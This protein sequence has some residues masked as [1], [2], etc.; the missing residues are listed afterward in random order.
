MP[1][2]LPSAFTAGIAVARTTPAVDG[3]P[4]T[5][6]LHP[7]P[8]MNV[9]TP[10]VGGNETSAYVLARPK[11]PFRLFFERDLHLKPLTELECYV[12]LLYVDDKRPWTKVYGAGEGVHPAISSP[13]YLDGEFGDHPDKGLAGTVDKK[14]VLMI[15]KCR[16]KEGT[17]LGSGHLLAADVAGMDQTEATKFVWQ[18]L[19]SPEHV[20]A[21]GLTPPEAYGSAPTPTALASPHL[22]GSTRTS[23]P[24][25]VKPSLEGASDP[26]NA[27]LRR[28]NSLL[29][30]LLTPSQKLQF[31]SNLASSPTLAPFLTSESRSELDSTIRTLA[32]QSLGEASG[33]QIPKPT[34]PLPRRANS[35]PS[36]TNTPSGVENEGPAAR[37]SGAALAGARRPSPLSVEVAGDGGA[38]HLRPPSIRSPSRPASTRPGSPRKSPLSGSFVQVQG[39]EEEEAMEAESEQMSEQVSGGKEA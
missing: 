11:Q 28:A 13:W 9:T 21:L 26:A 5:T 34:K 2:H 14:V 39:G 15:H 4:E 17:V 7:L 30:A 22:L 12:A 32:A 18:Y 25:Q 20:S 33:V 6:R 35:T 24:A 31:L 3:Q 27:F 36:V 10:A 38:L 16:M 37:L 1:T 29:L 19:T 8:E 23:S